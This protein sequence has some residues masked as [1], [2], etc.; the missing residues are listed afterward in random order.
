MEVLVFIWL[1]GAV[2]GWF[3]SLIWHLDENSRLISIGYKDTAMGIILTHVI[4]Y[5]FLAL[6]IWPWI[7][8]E[9][10]DKRKNND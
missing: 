3:N 7:I 5:W 4:W 10:A 6:F 8:K 9:I 2:Y 1:A